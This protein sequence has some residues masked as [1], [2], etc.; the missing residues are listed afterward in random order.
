MGLLI[1]GFSI[2]NFQFEDDCSRS[3]Q[4]VELLI[5]EVLSQ[6]KGDRISSCF[7]GGLVMKN[8]IFLLIIAAFLAGCTAE[9][10]KHDTVYKTNDHMTFSWW[11]YKSP[12]QE[13]LKASDSEG[14]WG[15]EIPYVPAE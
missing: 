10:Y 8:L 12:T 6:S 1:S 5:M 11:G 14:W 4:R 3:K 2:N 13:D 15:A 7:K 9:F